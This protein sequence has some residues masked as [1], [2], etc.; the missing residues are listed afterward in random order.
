M[1]EKS[2]ENPYGIIYN[3]SVCANCQDCRHVK[4]VVMQVHLLLEQLHCLCRKI[5]LVNCLYCVAR[6]SWSVQ[7]RTVAT[8]H[9]QI[10]IFMWLAGKSEEAFQQRTL[11]AADLRHCQ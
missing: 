6:P 5:A 9:T 10:R 11:F 2:D 7:L 3:C 1:P 8:N 4:I